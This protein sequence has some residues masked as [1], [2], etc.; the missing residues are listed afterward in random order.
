MYFLS[1]V[2]RIGKLIVAGIGLLAGGGVLIY[3]AVQ[4]LPVY[5][6]GGGLYFVTSLLLVF[7]SSKVLQDIKK[8][9]NRLQG[10]IDTFKEEN[11]KLAKERI[12]FEKNNQ[13]FSVNN[14]NLKQQVTSLESA[15]K[16]LEEENQKLAE[17]VRGVKTQLDRMD[18]LKHQYEEENKTLQFLSAE[19]DL[20]NEQLKQTAEKMAATQAVLKEENIKMNIMLDGVQAQLSAMERAKRQYEEENSKYRSLL[21]QNEEQIEKSEAQIDGMAGQI[22]KLRELHENSKQL[23]RNLVDAGDMFTNFSSTL[24]EDIS[25]LDNVTGDISGAANDLN[26][27]IKRLNLKLAHQ[28][29]AEADADG[30]GTVTKEEWDAFI[31]KRISEP[32]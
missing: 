28:Q 13:T 12:E 29:F 7:D 25:K 4:A 10:A 1:S 15:E 9:I 21:Q 19:Y 30:D 24:G 31:E 11:E 20:E 27:T 5:A 16:E 8:E 26:D 14:E 17:Q 3:G 2:Y 6:I 32:H 23:I 22:I 18:E